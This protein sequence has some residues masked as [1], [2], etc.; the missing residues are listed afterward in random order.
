MQDSHSR[1]R[2]DAIYQLQN[3][4]VPRAKEAIPFMLRALQDSD[5]VVRLDAVGLNQL[6][7]ANEI[8]L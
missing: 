7:P 3:I 8:H 1:I 4:G 6:V 5:F 2:Q